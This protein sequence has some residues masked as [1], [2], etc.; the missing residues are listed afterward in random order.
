MEG[1]FCSWFCNMKSAEFI[2]FSDLR[3]RLRS[4]TLNI[5][6]IPILEELHFAVSTPFV[7]L[8]SYLYD[9]VIGY[10]IVRQVKAL[11]IPRHPLPQMFYLNSLVLAFLNF[12]VLF[13]LCRPCCLRTTFSSLIPF[14][15]SVHR[16]PCPCSQ[17]CAY[18]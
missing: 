13:I 5:T 4:V 7:G 1:Y 6:C 16:I 8:Q 12:F 2:S 10:Q 3:L 14:S 17:V 11:F 15:K 9:L 18:V